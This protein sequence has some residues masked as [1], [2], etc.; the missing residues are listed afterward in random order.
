[1]DDNYSA[2]I[3][4]IIKGVVPEVAFAKFGLLETGF[5]VKGTPRSSKIT[6]DDIR[7]M[8]RLKMRRYTYKMIGEVYGK[9]DDAIHKIM[10]RA[11]YWTKKE[12]D[13]KKVF[14]A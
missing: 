10:K 1:M 14:R 11:R 8:Y 6:P 7:E 12:F 4:T 9:N 13:L 2:L 3:Y 5:T